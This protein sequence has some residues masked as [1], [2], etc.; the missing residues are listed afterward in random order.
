MC[1]QFKPN[2][3]YTS[4]TYSVSRLSYNYYLA[5]H[6]NHLN[7]RPHQKQLSVTIDRVVITIIYCETHTSIQRKHSS[8]SCHEFIDQW[9]YAFGDNIN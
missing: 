3:F 2:S 6:N 7:S 5:G 1:K 9:R 8:C 4:S